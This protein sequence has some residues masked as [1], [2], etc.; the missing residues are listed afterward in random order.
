MTNQA[1][2]A[3]YLNGIYQGVL[4]EIVAAQESDP[5][6][7]CFLQPYS[8]NYIRFLADS[9]ISASEPVRLYISTTELLPMVSY[10]ALVVKWEDKANL[11]PDRLD[12]LNSQVAQFQPDEEAIYLDI[13]GKP[14]VNL[15]TIA[16]MERLAH[17]VPVSTLVKIS[18][19]EPLQVR[20]RSGGWSPVFEC[21]DW[22]GMVP[23]IGTREYFESNFSKEVAESL[24]TTAEARRS[25]L[26]QASAL[27]ERFQVMSLAFKRNADVVAEVLC[28]A[29]GKCERCNCDAPFLRDSDGSPYLEIHHRKSLADEGD[30]TVANAIALCPNCHRELHFGCKSAAV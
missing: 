2:S 5:D 29:K 24:D 10:R 17:P 25:R 9:E 11:T 16:K 21:P 4:D 20:N 22:I 15:I 7:E 18:N 6:R 28:R 3:L 8:S 19:G 23:I 14:C 30:D 13:K 27:P 26:A 1:R 12:H